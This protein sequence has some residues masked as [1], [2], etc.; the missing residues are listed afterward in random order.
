MEGLQGHDRGPR[1]Q[2][3]VRVTDLD[4]HKD[5]QSKEL[6]D[7]HLFLSTQRQDLV[8]SIAHTNEAITKIDETTHARF[9]GAFTAINANFQVTCATCSAAGSSDHPATAP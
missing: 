8:D 5:E 9:R 1:R 4:I 3:R 7:P 2:R 6:E